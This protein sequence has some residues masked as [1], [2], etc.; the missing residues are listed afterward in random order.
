MNFHLLLVDDDN[1][2]GPSLKM[3]L[4]PHWKL[5]YS[6]S[7]T[8]VNFTF[9]Y[10]AAFVDMHLQ[11]DTNEPIGLKVIEKLRQQQPLLEIVAISG[12]FS[13]DLMEK[14]LLAGAQRFL[15]KP[16]VADEFLLHLSKIEALVQ[17]RMA[18]QNQNFEGPRWVGSSSESERIR[19]DIAALRGEAG[20]ILIYGESGCGKEVATR[21]IHSQEGRGPLISVN[22]ASITE[23]LFESELFGHIKGAFTGADANKIGL[24]E[25]A[26][27]G[28]LFLDEIEALPL[29]LQ[30]KMLRFLET[31]EYKKVGSKENQMAS[32]R[33]ICA[34][35]RDLTKMVREGLFREDLYW[36]ISGKRINLP[37][38]R[39]RRD[40]I[41]DL[42]D[43]F[44]SSYRP[45]RNK[46]FSTD[47]IEA[48]QNYAWPGN[49][50]ELKRV[51][52]Q[53]ILTSPLPVIR[54]I[55]V[56]G[57]TASSPVQA[58]PES[59]LDFEIG[60]NELTNRYEARVIGK[61]LHRC[62]H[63]IDATAELLKISRSNLY[64]KVK[65]YQIEIK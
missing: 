48:L 10:H 45:K 53:L 14:G 42:A 47:G 61:A 28:D 12:D 36:R 46:K 59:D 1:L 31:G 58:V 49:V 38:L 4:P 60:L 43:F 18:T 56:R 26:S 57:I 40:D 16:L 17:I 44:I 6:P 50:R 55:D 22:M 32:C 65:E 39:D 64:K 62:N 20:P 7:A 25:A 54:G 34:S 15:S 13:L 30:A 35:N 27:G 51:C 52:E 23:N 24:V 33:V 8:T 63:D 19:Q 29:S 2:I 5:I 41:V 3:I 9:P 11:G 37:P 21:M